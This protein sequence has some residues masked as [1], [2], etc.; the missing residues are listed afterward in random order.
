LSG[1]ATPTVETT[2][3][4]T[5]R[6]SLHYTTPGAL[7]LVH[8]IEVGDGLQPEK[9]TNI[10]ARESDKTIAVTINQ[11]TYLFSTQAPFAVASPAGT[12]P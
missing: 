6:V 4:N 7:K 5:H 8:L 9:T 1:G 2:A 12:R 10:V 3:V 11:I